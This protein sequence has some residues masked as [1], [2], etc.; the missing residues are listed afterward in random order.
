MF[1]HIVQEFLL[2]ILNH[3][4]LNGI[5]LHKAGKVIKQLPNSAVK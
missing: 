1:H 2:N 4:V 5:T 3:T